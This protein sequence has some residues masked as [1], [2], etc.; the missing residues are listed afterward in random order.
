MDTGSGM[1]WDAEIEDWGSAL[2]IKSTGWPMT[3]QIH[4]G[5]D[6]YRYILIVINIYL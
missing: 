5:I 6:R 4:I 2:E 1:W 3:K